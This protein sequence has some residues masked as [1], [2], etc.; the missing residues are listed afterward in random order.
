MGRDEFYAGIGSGPGKGSG[1]GVGF[2]L[3]KGH[4]HSPAIKQR[5]SGLSG[6]ISHGVPALSIGRSC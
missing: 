4:S 1:L 3:V 5:L 6:G 2:G